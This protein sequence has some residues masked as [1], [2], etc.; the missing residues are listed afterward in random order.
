MRLVRYENY[1]I[2]IEPELLLLKPFKK[3]FNNDRTKTKSKFMEFITLVYFTIDPRSDFSYITDEESRL[4][5]V[6][7]VNG[8]TPYKFNADEKECIELYRQMTTTASLRL[9]KNTQVA[10]DRIG[11]YL[12]N[13]DMNEKDDKGKLVNSIS[14]VVSAVDKIP[15]L[16]AKVSEAEK[17]IAKELEEKGRARGGNTKKLFEDG[18]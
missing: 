1:Q 12:V 15:Q 10:I 18:F 8:I 7:K 2:E 16:V 17:A 9:L 11:D 4:Q 3:V 5:E 14:Q 6:F 13:I